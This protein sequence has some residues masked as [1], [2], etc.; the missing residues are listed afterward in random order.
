[1]SARWY[2]SYL[3]AAA[4]T[5]VGL[6]GTPAQADP[7]SALE[8]EGFFTSGGPPGGAGGG[9]N[10]HPG[11]VATA[12]WTDSTSGCCVLGTPD[13]TTNIISANTTL[14]GVPVQLIGGDDTGGFGALSSL[15]LS[16][17]SVAHMNGDLGS[18]WYFTVD[19]SGL[20]VDWQIVKIIVKAGNV[21]DGIFVTTSLFTPT[22]DLQEAFISD[23]EFAAWQ[24]AAGRTEPPADVSHFMALGTPTEVPEPGTL[25][26][27]GLSLLGLG[28]FARRKSSGS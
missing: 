10:L 25:A 26:L 3:V 19:F 6:A 15:T 22:D 8:W 5:L 18:G 28:M 1:M 27:V 7:I 17:F 4:I 12:T 24:A 9:K 23:A 16:D 2:G 11:E 20:S 21:Q 13:D 14:L